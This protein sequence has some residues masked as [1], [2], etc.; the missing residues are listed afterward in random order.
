LHP[1]EIP[2]RPWAT[3]A[4]D[5]V[6]GLPPAEYGGRVVDSIL[7][8]TCPFSKMV[9]LMPLPSTATAEDVAEVVFNGVYR[10]FGSP[11][12]L[13]SDRDPK[14]TSDF[15][16]SFNRKM[17]IEL[18]MSTSAHPQTDGRSEVT[19]KTVGQVLRIL[20]AD[21]PSDWA[22]Q[23]TAAEFALNSAP[24]SA[25]GLSPFEVVYGFLPSPWPVDSWA[26]TGNAA[27]EARAEVARRDWLRV[28]DAIIASRVDMTHEANKHRRADSPAFVVG[29]KAYLS[30]SGISFPS[31]L[32]HKF[33]PKFLGPFNIVSANPSTSNYT[34]SLP[35]HLRIHPTFHASKLRPFFPNDSSRFPSRA[36]P[37]PPPVIPGADAGEAEWELEKV[38]AVRTVRQKRMFKVRYLGY[39]E[40]EDQWRSELEL[41]ETAPDLLDA[42][43]AQHNAVETAGAAAPSRRRR[44]ARLVSSLLSS[45]LTK[46]TLSSGG[47]GAR[48]T[49]S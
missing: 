3:A 1:L 47:V 46:P 6:V 14:F 23:V 43:L 11:V 12:C 37:E 20:C 28:T 7:T 41:R 24:A 48:I 2:S 9:V 42:F 25:T 49:P 16:R 35:P 45:F 21:S 40:S 44:S 22:R 26:Q 18:K 36:F 39:S 10:R 38:V 34:L 17:G 15:W 5:F 31:G 29:G 19:N 4:V 32:S 8:A 13:V 30:S 27:V 33:L